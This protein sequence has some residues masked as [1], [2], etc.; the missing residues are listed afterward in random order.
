MRATLPVE[1]GGCSM[2]VLLMALA[3]QEAPREK[4]DLLCTTTP[5]GS[6]VSYRF[7]IDPV[8]RSF[9][10]VMNDEHRAGGVADVTETTVT[11]VQEERNLRTTYTISR[12]TGDLVLSAGLTD[13]FVAVRMNGSCSKFSG[14]RF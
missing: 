12:T 6:V 13:G 9:T 7:S 4:L 8:A 3:L 2:L 10:S 5:N 11:L 1:L 14:R